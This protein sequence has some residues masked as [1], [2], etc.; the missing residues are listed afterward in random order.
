MIVAH[1]ADTD[2]DGAVTQA[3]FTAAALT[4]FDRLDANKDG[5]VTK[6][7]RQAARKAMRE[8]WRAKRQ[9]APAETPAG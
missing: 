8:Q 1:M 2:K 9:G 7:E 6:K 4:G 3:E 5:Q